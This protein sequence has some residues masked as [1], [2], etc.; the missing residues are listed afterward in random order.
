MG[1]LLGRGGESVKRLAFLTGTRVQI[2]PPEQQQDDG[3]DCAQYK[4]VSIRGDSACIER[5]KA[6]VQRLIDALACSGQKA[7]VINP[8]AATSPE[9]E[10]ELM[11]RYLEQQSGMLP[12]WAVSAPA[13][14]SHQTMPAYYG[15]D[16]AYSAGYGGYCGAPGS[17][18]GGVGG[19]GAAGGYGVGTGVEMSG[20]G[21]G[22]GGMAQGQYYV[23]AQPQGYGGAIGDDGQ[24]AMQMQHQGYGDGSN[25]N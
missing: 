19:Y 16:P 11:K 4:K 20:L 3:F 18:Y 5:A 2:L 13:A 21:Y 10:R 7:E 15:A 12:E 24:M 1:T 25:T 8:Q 14:M 22:A 17:V 23:P 9:E 6:E